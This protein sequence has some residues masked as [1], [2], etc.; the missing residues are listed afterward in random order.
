[1]TVRPD[2]LGRARRRS[3]TLVERSASPAA[4]SA[5]SAPIVDEQPRGRRPSGWA[6]PSPRALALGAGERAARPATR[7]AGSVSVDPARHRRARRARRAPCRSTPRTPHALARSKRLELLRI[8]ARDLLGLDPLETVGAALADLAQQ[9]LDGAVVAGGTAG[10]APLGRH[11]YGKARWA[12]AQLRQRRGRSLRQP[13][14]AR[15]RRGPAHPADRAADASGSTSISAPKDGPGRSTRSLDSYRAYWGRWAATWEFQALL[16]ARAVAGDGELGRRF[17]GR[18]RRA[19]CGSRNYSADELAA[20]RIH[21]GPDRRVSWPAAASWGARS[22]AARVGS[23]TSNS[24]SSSCSSCTAATT[25]DQGP[26]DPRRAG[27]AG[28]GRVRGGRGRERSGRRLPVSA[29]RGAP[30]AARRGGPDPLGSRPTA[31]ARRR[32]AL[33]LGFADDASALGHGPLRR[34]TAP[35]PTRRAGHPRAALLPPPSRSVRHRRRTGPDEP[36]A[37]SHGRTGH[38]GRGGGPASRRLRLL[39]RHPHPGRGRGPR[40]WPDPQFPAHGPAASRSCSTGCRS[41]PTPTSG[42]SGCAIS[43]CTPTSV[44]CSSPRSGNPPRRPGAC[45]CCSGRAGH[46]SRRSSAIPELIAD[47]RRRRAAR[48]HAP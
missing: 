47:D 6:V 8:A 44:R 14:R 23:G 9:V 38:V 3:S 1:M 18:R 42:S 30:A 35:V 15:R 33:V 12:R 20:V 46:W 39:R 43:S 17:R 36:E 19:R 29:H 4:A 24:R 37:R 22:S 21:E 34:R 2:R 40:R 26:L 5:T 31:S 41:R 28:R 11:R 45:A 32:L 10:Q 13:R 16:K 48:P 7:W 27:R 25:R